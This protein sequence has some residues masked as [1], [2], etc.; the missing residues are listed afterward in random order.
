MKKVI[1]IKGVVI[2]VIDPAVW[3][4]IFGKAVSACC[5]VF[6]FG[7]PYISNLLKSTGHIF[8]IFCMYFIY[9]VMFFYCMELPIFYGHHLLLWRCVVLVWT[10]ITRVVYDF[11][12]KNANI[13]VNFVPFFN[14]IL[15][16]FCHF[17]KSGV[18]NE[19]RSLSL[20]EQKSQWQYKTLLLV[21]RYFGQHMHGAPLQPH[22]FKKRVIPE[23][24][25]YFKL[26]SFKE[27]TV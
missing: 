4:L 12:T 16:L 9:L 3:V 2:F 25:S 22:F 21:K 11:I 19:L 23:L 5:M 13:P 27:M 24:G 10:F 6:I 15:F 17:W 7:V 14:D 8:H 1:F 26:A 18:T 20:K